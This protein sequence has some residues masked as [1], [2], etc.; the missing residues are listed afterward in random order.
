[1][2]ECAR[3]RVEDV[4]VTA[5]TGTARLHGK[6]DQ[7]RTVPIPAPGRAGIGDYLAERGRANGLRAG[8]R[9]VADLIERAS[10]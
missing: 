10:P 7:V 5:R 8:Q 1:M 3:L 9:E 6:R 2:Q 4:A